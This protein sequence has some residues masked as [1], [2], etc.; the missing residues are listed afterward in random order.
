MEGEQ[1]IVPP[2]ERY[3]LQIISWKIA[4][5]DEVKKDQELCI[6]EYLDGDQT[7]REVLRS[8]FE[9]KIQQLKDINDIYENGSVDMGDSYIS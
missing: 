4:V 3:P 1:A 2:M 9:G 6:Y 5:G 8:K 7:K